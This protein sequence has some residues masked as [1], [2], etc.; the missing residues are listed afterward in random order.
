[1]KKHASRV[2]GL[3]MAAAMSLTASVRADVTV[4]QKTSLDV[5]SVIHSHGMTTTRITPD[6]KRYREELFATPE[7]LAAA[8][9][10]GLMDREAITWGDA[11]KYLAPYRAQIKQLTDKSA[12]FKGQP[13]RTSLRVLMGGEQCSATANMKANGSSGGSAATGN[14]PI[15]NVTQAGKALASSVGHLVG[16]LFH[17]KTADAAPDAASAASPAAPTAPDPFA[18]YLQ[19]AAFSTETVTIGTEAI[20]AARFDV[21]PDWNKEVLEA[22]KNGD[23]DCTCPKS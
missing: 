13:L 11:Q 21:P 10:L 20:P 7:E 3:A 15:A 6:K 18:K 14:N 16:G 2:I 23:A 12:D 8:K 19:V 22:G 9:K 1:M 4:Q 5:A 17:K